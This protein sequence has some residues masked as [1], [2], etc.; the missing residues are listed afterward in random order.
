MTTLSYVFA[1]VLILLAVLAVIGII[2]YDSQG[3]Q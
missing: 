3:P 2:I 1:G